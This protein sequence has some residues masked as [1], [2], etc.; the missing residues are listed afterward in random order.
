MN[1]ML[2]TI[3]GLLEETQ[4]QRDAL[5]RAAERL[6]SD[7]RLANN[8]ELDIKAAVNNDPIGMLGNAFSF[9]VGRFRHFLSRN[10]TTIKQLDGISRRNQ[11]HVESFITNMHNLLHNTQ[12]TQSLSPK[13][14]VGQSSLDIRNKGEQESN[15]NSELLIQATRMHQYL[16]QNV[17]QDME[18][19]GLHLL[20]QIERIYNLCHHIELE[21]QSHNGKMTPANLQGMRSL[22]TQLRELRKNAQTFQNNAAE[23]LKE[24]DSK[25]NSLLTVARL[26]ET[27]RTSQ[28]TIAQVQELTRIAERFARDVTTLAQSLRMVT[29]DM[30]SSLAPFRLEVAEKQ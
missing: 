8:G 14:L 22:A 13:S 11:E 7:M 12:E 1:T 16:R 4:V 30:Q 3:V 9:T 2:D 27:T 26:I 28:L 25:I 17:Q 19:K 20:S 21:L 6:F 5:V 29:Q 10:Y 23:N 15:G 18:Q 24:M